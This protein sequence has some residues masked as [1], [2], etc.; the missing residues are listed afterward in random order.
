MGLQAGDARKK[1]PAR[2]SGA[3]VRKSHGGWASPNW[4]RLAVAVQCDGRRRTVRA[5]L[6]GAPL[7][8]TLRAVSRRRPRW[9]RP[10]RAAGGGRTGMPAAFRSPG[11][12]TPDTLSAG[13]PH[14]RRPSRRGGRISAP[15]KRKPRRGNRGFK[16][17]RSSRGICDR[18]LIRSKRRRNRIVA[19]G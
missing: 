7:P 8:P 16:V 10:P 12:P 4:Q 13:R 5:F 18:S 3:A 9:Q 19:S 1:I 6:T 14:G 2:R 15:A 11:L 17:S